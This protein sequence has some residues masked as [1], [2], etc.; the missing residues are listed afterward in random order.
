MIQ[1]RWCTNYGSP[2]HTGSH[3]SIP[4]LRRLQ[5]VPIHRMSLSTDLSECSRRYTNQLSLST[6]I[7]DD[8]YA[9]DVT[10]MYWMALCTDLYECSASSAIHQVFLC[11]MTKIKK[12]LSSSGIMLHLSSKL[13]K[14]SMLHKL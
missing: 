6:D 10:D 1:M 5:N 14:K 13:K 12:F 4:D 8:L 3:G 11:D 2:D 9:P 7:T